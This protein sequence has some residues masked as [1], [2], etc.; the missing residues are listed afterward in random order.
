MVKELPIALILQRLRYD[1]DTG[2]L[3][4]KE[5]VAY[6]IKVGDEAGSKTARG[7]AQL[8]INRIPYTLHRVVFAMHTLKSV[9]M[10]ID[11]IDGDRLNNRIENLREASPSLNAQNRKKTKGCYEKYGRWYAYITIK[12]KTTYLGGYST[13]KEAHEA[14]REAKKIYHPECERK[15]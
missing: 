11:H 15:I 3:Y 9:F 4:W 6:G 14:Y 8:Y 2:K 1:A 5:S 12:R 10:E 7:Y 13:E